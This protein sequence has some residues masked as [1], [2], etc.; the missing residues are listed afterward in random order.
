M[1]FKIRLENDLCEIHI[2]VKVRLLSMFIIVMILVLAP[3]GLGRFNDVVPEA[4]AQRSLSCDRVVVSLVD[5][6]PSSGESSAN[7]NNEKDNGDGDSD[8]GDHNE[9]QKADKT[10]GDIES[11]I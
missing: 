2:D 9:D 6:P 11:K 8:K 3:A 5:C 7:D 1:F 4:H 10:G